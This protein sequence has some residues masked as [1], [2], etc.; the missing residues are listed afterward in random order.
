MSENIQYLPGN[1]PFH[2]V[3]TKRA[4][5]KYDRF[6]LR[7]NRV[8]DIAS[9]FAGSFMPNKYLPVQ[10]VD[11]STEQGVVIPMDT[12]VAVKSIPTSTGTN[13]GIA[14]NTE[15][16]VSGDGRLVISRDVDGDVVAFNANDPIFGY[17]EELQAIL[18]I[19]NGGVDVQDT[20][21]VLDEEVGTIKSNGDIAQAAENAPLRTANIPVGIVIYDIWQDI[22][23]KYMNYQQPT[24][25]GATVMNQGKLRIPFVKESLI[26]A[27]GDYNA[28]YTAIKGAYP[29]LIMPDAGLTEGV[30]LMPNEH[31][32]FIPYN[33]AAAVTVGEASD[34]I[35]GTY[36][37][38][39]T[40]LVKSMINYVD[41]YPGSRVA[42]MDTGGVE[43]VMYM[44]IEEVLRRN[45]LAY[46]QNDILNAIKTGSFGIAY[47]S[48][49]KS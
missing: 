28:A 20:Y 1:S 11:V 38:K 37:F 5:G 25:L 48:I 45:S 49:H 47:I 42:G 6:K 36:F 27:I 23:G 24:Q 10:F 8:E 4:P 40:R 16:G 7:W 26:G 33:S 43:Q 9:T 12:I 35:I 17:T 30:K 21:T 31:G 13:S 14:G 41:T 34:Q 46:T 3:P 22:R 32:K 18:T 29:F 15:I 19:A 44:F 2:K 39:D